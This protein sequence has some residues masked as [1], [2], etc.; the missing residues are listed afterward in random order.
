MLN[1]LFPKILRVKLQ[2]W[3]F[4]CKCTKIC[5]IRKNTL[6]PQTPWFSWV[7]FGNS[8]VS[9]QWYES[10]AIKVLFSVFVKKVTINEN[11][12][13]TVWSS[14]V[15]N[16]A[17]ELLI[18]QKSKKWQWHHNLP[19]WF[20]HQ[21][22][23]IAVFAMS[24]LV[25]GTSLIYWL[26]NYDNF[27]LYRIDKKSDIG[28]T[29][30]WNLFNLWRLGW[31]RDTKFCTNVSNEKYWILQNARVKAVTISESL[32]ENQQAVKITHPPRIGL[33][34]FH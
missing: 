31:F 12:A 14:K 3:N 20:H 7:F 17:S 4:T 24:S 8:I 9:K 22:F 26:W 5:S 28:N 6:V 33:Q 23:E 13:F 10:C 2:T 16:L 11:V 18:D 25:N 27:C 29:T 34:Q 21:F 15:W 19:T 32:R 30:V 1:D